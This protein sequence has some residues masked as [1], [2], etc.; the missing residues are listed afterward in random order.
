MT[1][2][3]DLV[4]LSNRVRGISLISFEVGI[5]KLVCVCILGW[6]SVRFHN[7]VSVTLNLTSDLVSRNRIESG[8]YLQYSLR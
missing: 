6:Q 5:S 3:S 1:F 4:F 8:A 2:T 7:L